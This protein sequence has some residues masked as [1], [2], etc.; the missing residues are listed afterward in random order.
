MRVISLQVGR[1]QEVEW[2][3]RTVRTGIYKMPVAGP[4]RVGPTGLEADEQADPTVHGG[5]DK[6][7]YLYP[8][9]HYGPWRAEL[10]GIELPWGSF[11]ENLTIEGLVE[12]D[13]GI[14]DRF[15]AGSV[16]L[17]VRQPR[18]PCFKLGMRFG[19]PGMLK[20][21]LASERSGFYCAVERAGVLS[22]GD[23]L[24]PVERH[25]VRLTVLDVVR[26]RAGTTVDA[27]LRRR[28]LQHPGLPAAFRA[29]LEQRWAG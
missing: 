28:A 23:P 5:S 22:A 25:P 9:E 20:R 4:V 10:G 21:F 8:S 15:R 16:L 26:L 7:V 18:F 11:G 2:D 17:V 24:E 3:G 14:G 12:G 6:A 1:A 13:V 29:G 19:D 27:D